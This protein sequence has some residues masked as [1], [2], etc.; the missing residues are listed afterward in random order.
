[1]IEE[2]LHHLRCVKACKLLMMADSPY[3]GAGFLPSTVGLTVSMMFLFIVS[4]FHFLMLMLL[5]VSG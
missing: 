1:L 3:Y 5:Y 2:I 4:F